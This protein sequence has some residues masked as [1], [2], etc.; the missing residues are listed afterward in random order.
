MDVFNFSR[1]KLANLN[2][3]YFDPVIKRGE[4]RIITYLLLGET[5][6]Y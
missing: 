2:M 3:L 4:Y 5:E 6:I 1:E